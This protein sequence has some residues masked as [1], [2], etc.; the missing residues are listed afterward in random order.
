MYYVYI[1][2]S[3]EG[4]YYVGQ[5]ENVEKR[6]E[7]HNSKRYKGWTNRCNGWDVVYTESFE[8]RREAVVREHEIKR[9]KGGMEFKALLGS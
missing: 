6:L 8:T 7:Q 2:K 5:T 3:I 1:I 9:M 4:R